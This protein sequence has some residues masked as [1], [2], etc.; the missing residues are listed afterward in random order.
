M[1]GHLTLF[2]FVS[3][4]S[5]LTCLS[6]CISLSLCLSRPPYPVACLTRLSHSSLSL[7]LRIRCLDTYRHDHPSLSSLSLYFSLPPLCRVTKGPK[8]NVLWHLRD[9]GAR[10]RTL[11]MVRSHSVCSSNSEDGRVSLSESEPPDFDAKMW[12]SRDVATTSEKKKKR[13]NKEGAAA[14]TVALV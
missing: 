1:C 10:A 11:A 13:R 12:E 9:C 5:P 8:S 3:L 7:S 4:G 6:L 2:V 14:H